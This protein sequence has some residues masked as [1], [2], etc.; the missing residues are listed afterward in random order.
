MM[1]EALLLGLVSAF[2]AVIWA[3]SSRGL[4]KQPMEVFNATTPILI[5]AIAAGHAVQVLKRYYEEYGK[6]K[7]ASPDKDPKELSRLAIVATMTRIGP[8]M[9]VACT[10]AALGFFSLYIFE[11]KSVQTFGI[12]TGIGVLSAKVLEFKFIPALRSALNPPS[13]KGRRREQERTLWDRLLERIY[14]LALHRRRALTAITGPFL[15]C[16]SL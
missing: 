14:H 2:I 3:F 10:V 11:I 15:V 5:L 1:F 7:D 13:D 16:V 8:V 4:L 6:L 12:L 9:A